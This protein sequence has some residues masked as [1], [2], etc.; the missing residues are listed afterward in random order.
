MSSLTQA[1]LRYFW[2]TKYPWIFAFY[3]LTFGILTGILKKHLTVCGQF[4]DVISRSDCL[5]QKSVFGLDL[6]MVAVFTS[7]IFLYVF[8]I[9]GVRPAE[10]E[11]HFK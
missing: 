11:H 4:A 5:L 6:F 10:L 1:R 9:F 7:F 2:R 8:Y 3:L